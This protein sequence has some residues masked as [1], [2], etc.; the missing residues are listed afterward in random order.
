MSWTFLCMGLAVLTSIRAENPLWISEIEEFS[1]LSDHIVSRNADKLYRLPQ[2]VV[3]LE[4]DIY[5]DLYFAEATDRPFSF[6]GRTSI[7]IQVF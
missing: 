7:L 6:D 4:Y 2:N 1:D 3:P 5:I